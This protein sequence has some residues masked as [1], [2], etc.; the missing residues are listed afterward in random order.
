MVDVLSIQISSHNIPD[1]RPVGL[2]PV[3][4]Q[5]NLQSVST[6]SRRGQP[7]SEETNLI[8]KAV[9]SVNLARKCVRLHWPEIWVNSY[10]GF[11]SYRETFSNLSTRSNLVASF[12]VIE[13][14]CQIAF[15]CSLELVCSTVDSVCFLLPVIGK[16]PGYHPDIVGTV[17]T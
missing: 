1:A 12:E 11:G 7:V 3:C 13:S 17:Q 15:G 10:P 16:I 5:Y 9:F 6:W 14:N 8:V 4:G 2:D